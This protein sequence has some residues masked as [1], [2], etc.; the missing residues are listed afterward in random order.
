LKADVINPAS[1]VLN[2]E[3]NLVHRVHVFKGAIVLVILNF[4]ADD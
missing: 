1:Q 2:G 4:R 3:K